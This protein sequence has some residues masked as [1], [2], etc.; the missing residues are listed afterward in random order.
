MFFFVFAAVEQNL[1]IYQI[2]G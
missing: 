2:N 1:W